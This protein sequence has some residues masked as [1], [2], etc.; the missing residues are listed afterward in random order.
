VKEFPTDA[1]VEHAI[2]LFNLEPRIVKL[3]VTRWLDTNPFQW[4]MNRTREFWSIKG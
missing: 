4:A 2:S 1:L 3:E